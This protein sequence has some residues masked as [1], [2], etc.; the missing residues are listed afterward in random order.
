MK[1]LFVSLV[2]AAALAGCAVEPLY[3]PD[4]GTV[5]GNPYYYGYYSDPYY[6]YGRPYAYDYDRHYYYDPY[7]GRYYR[8]RG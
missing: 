3:N 2:A 1:I 8:R 7:T 6:Y 5:I 4:Q